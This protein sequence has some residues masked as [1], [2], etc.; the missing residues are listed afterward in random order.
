MS[1][2]SFRK[3]SLKL[4]KVLDCHS[5][6]NKITRFFNEKPIKLQFKEEKL[7]NNMINKNIS[8]HLQDFPD[9][10]F[11]ENNEELV[12]NMDLVRLICS[13]ALSMRDNKNLRVRLPLKKLT[14][15]G[16][17]L[18]KIAKFKDIISDEVNVKS[19]EIQEN[20]EELADLNLKINFKKIGAKFGSKIKEIMAAS[21]SGDYNKISEN[22]IEI[23]GVTLIDDDFELNLTPK[24]KIS[25]NEEIIALPDNSNLIA[26][27]IKITPELKNEGIA[28]DIVR[29]V[30]QARK[31]AK[32]EVSDKINLKIFAKT[33]ITQCL[34]DFT[35]YIKDQVLASSVEVCKSPESLKLGSEFCATSKIEDIELLIGINKT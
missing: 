3:L 9:V 6:I 10:N 16:K 22:K 34:D 13:S 15:I 20:I 21:K 24:N 11:I 23:A 32:L 35:N 30:Q 2:T 25:E 19:V 17:N 14:I 1:Q 4:S 5:E 7:Q 31:D 28:R 33:E 29:A 18:E 12:K 26:L 8:I 27:D